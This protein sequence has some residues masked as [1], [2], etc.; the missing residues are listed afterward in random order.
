MTQPHPGHCQVTRSRGL[1]W[2]LFL[3]AGIL[4]LPNPA[5]AHELR[6]A[7]ANMVINDSGATAIEIATNVEALIAGIGPQHGDTARAPNAETY[8]Q[9]RLNDPAAL[10]TEF[11]RFLETFLGGVN[12]EVDGTQVPPRFQAIDIP[13]VGEPSLA[14]ISR[15]RLET[16]IP[17]D[18]KSVVWRYAGEF[19]DSIF[20]V[21]RPDD[22]EPYFAAYVSAGD[23]SAPVPVDRIIAQPAGA[24]FANYVAVGFAHILPK[25]LDHILFMI[26]LFLLSPRLRPLTWQV[27]GFTVAHSITLALGIYGLVKIPP[28]IVEPI[29]A[30]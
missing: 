11:A 30:A 1:L 4:L 20:R 16:R 26:G 21:R 27:T 8:E 14:R 7:I 5:S 12:L 28:S 17:A 9:L 13:P 18:A 10:R 19:G 23:N 24:V 3:A 6:P 2:V 15:I 29:I 25:G 22:V